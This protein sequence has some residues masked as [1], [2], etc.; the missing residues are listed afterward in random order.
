MPDRFTVI[1]G[2]VYF[3]GVILQGVLTATL[4][5][6]YPFT[7]AVTAEGAVLGVHY[8]GNAKTALVNLRHRNLMERT[9]VA[10]PC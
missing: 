9:G 1:L 4:L 2:A 8:Y 6:H 10:K 5:P 3:V 7:A